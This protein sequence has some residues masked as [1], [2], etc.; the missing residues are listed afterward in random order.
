[1]CTDTGTKAVYFG[2]SLT[3]SE[4]YSAA[5]SEW[6]NC[7]GGSGKSPAPDSPCHRLS[8][9]A[10]QEAQEV[11]TVVGVA[12]DALAV[13]AAVHD[14]VASG[15]G[16]LPPARHSRHGVSLGVAGTDQVGRPVEGRF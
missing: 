9:I 4:I 3:A 13:V 6:A 16:P 11:A 14:V 12:E 15:I 8:G 10:G 7:L 2:R 1:M 5:T